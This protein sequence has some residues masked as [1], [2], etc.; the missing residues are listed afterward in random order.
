MCNPDGHMHMV[1]DRHASGCRHVY[2]LPAVQLTFVLTRAAVARTG[3]PPPRRTPPVVGFPAA[4]GAGCRA[5]QGEG[6]WRQPGCQVCA[7]RGSTT[8]G[9]PPVCSTTQGPPPVCSHQ[10]NAAMQ[11]GR[12]A[13][14]HLPPGSREGATTGRSAALLRSR[15][16]AAAPSCEAGSRRRA[17]A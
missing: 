9:L 6:G 8:Q 3:G 4:D 14:K 5:A 17:A 12:P 16:A 13:G 7:T 11:P 2:P 15:A 1:C 10:D